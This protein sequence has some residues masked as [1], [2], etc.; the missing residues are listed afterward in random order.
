M[1]NPI[2]ATETQTP[3][4][5]VSMSRDNL[6]LLHSAARAIYAQMLQIEDPSVEVTACIAM[7]NTAIDEGHD[8]LDTNRGFADEYV[9]LFGGVTRQQMDNIKKFMEMEGFEP[10]S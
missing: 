1:P 2:L 9:R 6:Q 3:I 8:V 10:I 4:K 5:T 7:L